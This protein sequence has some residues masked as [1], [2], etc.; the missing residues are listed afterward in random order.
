MERSKEIT[1]NSNQKKMK[2]KLSAKEKYGYYFPRLPRLYWIDINSTCN[3]RCIMCPQVKGGFDRQTEMSV[4]MFKAIIDDICR[5]RPLIKLYMSG[6]PLLHKDLFTMIEYAHSKGCQTM[7]HTNATL[8]T[9]EIALKLLSSRLNYLTFSFDGCS[10]EIYE[11]LRRPAKYDRVKSNILQFLELRSKNGVKNPHTTIEII[12]MEDTECLI[13]EFITFWE[14]SGADAVNVRP[15]LTW[16]NTIGDRSTEKP[17]RQGYKPC[18]YVFNSGCILSDGT[19]VACCMDVYGK[20]T[21]GN[22]NEEPFRAIWYGEKY[23][24]L[25]KKMID[26]DLEQNSICLICENTAI[27]DRNSD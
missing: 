14:K 12:R 21:L 2:I 15:Y 9:E 25:R 23:L 6:E 13:E 24:Q 11:K 7:V 8:L 4:G 27:T 19:V 26:G 16:L 17:T 22:I 3:L 20:I 18:G 10:R 1:L 5:N